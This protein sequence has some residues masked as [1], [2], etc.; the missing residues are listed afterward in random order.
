[1]NEHTAE[2]RFIL[3]DK[4]HAWALLLANVG[5]T[6]QAR[7]VK[8]LRGKDPDGVMKVR[9]PA[10]GLVTVKKVLELAGA[11]LLRS[12]KAL[13][14]R[15]SYRDF[16][17]A[18]DV[19]DVATFRSVG[20]SAVLHPEITDECSASTATRLFASGARAAKVHSSAG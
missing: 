7:H 11:E 10:A 5:F 15:A 12:A 9:G 1:M 6:V 16:P 14:P 4:I 17:D 13:R 19:T 2:F 8:P 18:A 20:P 3:D